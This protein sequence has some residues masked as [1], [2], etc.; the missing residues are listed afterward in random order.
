MLETGV[1]VHNPIRVAPNGA[2]STVIFT[3]LR[4]P[5]VSVQQFNQDAN[6]VERDLATLKA[7]IEK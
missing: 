6:A 2:G 5:G 3:L 7:V 1:T 4:Q